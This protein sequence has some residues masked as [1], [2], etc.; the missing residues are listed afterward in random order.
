MKQ[1]T[2]FRRINLDIFYAMG[3][4][5][6]ERYKCHPLFLLGCKLFGHMLLCLMFV[7]LA[8]CPTQG[9]A[10]RIESDVIWNK[11]S[12]YVMDADT[13]RVLYSRNANKKLHPASLTKLMTLL[14]VFDAL[15]RGNLGLHSRIRISQH[16]ASMPPSKLNLPAGSTI[17]VNDAI[18]A[19]VTKSANDIAVALAEKL[20]GTESNF[21][22]MMNRK[23]RSLG[24]RNT[25]FKN[26]S[27][28]HHPK[29]VSTARDMAI[30]A[31]V[32]VTDY[33]K[34]YHYFSVKSFSYDGTTYS[35]HNKLMKSYEGMDGMKTGYI[36]QS[37]F[38]LVASAVRGNHRLIGIV[39]GG[40]TGKSRNAHMKRLLDNGFERVI[41]IYIL[42]NE[43]PIP[44][45]K[46]LQQHDNQYSLASLKTYSEPAT[47]AQTIV[48][49]PPEKPFV[50]SFDSSRDLNEYASVDNNT[51]RWD[52][53]D[54]SR[55]DSM[56]NRMIGEGDYDI[57]V[58]NRIETGLI[59]ISAQMHNIQTEK[60][61]IAKIPTISADSSPSFI[62][63]FVNAGGVVL[64]KSDTAKKMAMI[65]P[66][67]NS[68]QTT[69]TYV[70]TTS[71]SKSNLRGNW[72]IQV[73][74]FTSREQTEKA[75][76]NTLNMLPPSLS[77]TQSRVAPLKTAQGWIYRARFEGYSKA[78]AKGACRL[79]PDC[80]ALAPVSD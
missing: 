42:A 40:R 24:M 53:L 76:A 27:G 52:M 63:S 2:V 7:S 12:S 75:L 22:Y 72:S 35:N 49:I 60:T 34:Y 20:G 25:R 62:A 56:F 65:E 71:A 45:R 70:K 37:G 5:K 14:M 6:D 9:I 61:N 69:N 46:P 80:I 54:S 33:K 18:L 77:N 43:A 78:A 36:R 16:A 30:L 3:K 1:L 21:S 23:A 26:A 39:F 57:T 11:Y 58:R 66:S 48:P 55:E 15:E 28:L 32:M 10:K 47:S 67:S 41:G 73:G 4:M 64:T 13:G 68:L 38:N 19:L 51:S 79:L 74:A 59:A 29:Q 31:R 44:K 8:L 17:K 50:N